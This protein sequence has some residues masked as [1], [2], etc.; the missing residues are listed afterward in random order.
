MH[1]CISR[2]LSSRKIWPADGDTERYALV[3]AMPSKGSHP[4]LRHTTNEMDAAWPKTKLKPGN[5]EHAWKKFAQKEKRFASPR[6]TSSHR[7]K[8]ASKERFAATSPAGEAKADGVDSSPGP[9]GA[10]QNAWH[11][12]EPPKAELRRKPLHIP[13]WL[14]ATKVVAERALV[15]R[16]GFLL[17]SPQASQIPAGTTLY[18]IEARRLNGDVRGLVAETPLAG[19]PALG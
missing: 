10:E 2:D 18:L 13:R 17:E 9:G 15:V 12:H 14:N 3:A 6:A 5:A 16:E 7:T 4:P 8:R 19:V 1:T 11:P